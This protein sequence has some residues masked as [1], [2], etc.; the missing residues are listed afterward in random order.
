MQSGRHALR[1]GAREAFSVN[2]KD[3]S[4]YNYSEDTLMPVTPVG[5]KDDTIGGRISFA[6]DAMG[7]TVE[8]ISSVAGVTTETWCNWE[9]DRSEPRANR[10][11]MLARI[12]Q[13]NIAW[14]IDGQ[15][16]GPGENEARPA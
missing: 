10:L 1:A 13:T 6:R 16:K 2:R 3:L 4:M 14:L 8:Q 15:G 9:N 5:R 11:D 7:L 12:L